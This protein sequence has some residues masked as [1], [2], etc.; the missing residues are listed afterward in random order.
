MERPDVRILTTDAVDDEFMGFE[1]A[2]LIAG[3]ILLGD[4][5]EP[6]LSQV[7]FA[8]SVA[9]LGILL[10]E[11]DV[12]FVVVKPKEGLVEEASESL[13]T[14]ET[15]VASVNCVSLCCNT[16]LAEVLDCG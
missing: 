6:D 11:R 3:V 7:T 16:F 12:P 9:E 14:P 2:W 10:C 1:V 13:S 15:L 8:G 5:C 4:A